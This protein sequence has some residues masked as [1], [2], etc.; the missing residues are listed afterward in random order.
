MPY[1]NTSMSTGSAADWD[2]VPPC[3]AAH[4]YFSSKHVCRSEQMTESVAVWS[5]W[6]LCP[7]THSHHKSSIY[8]WTRLSFSL[9]VVQA[10]VREYKYWQESQSATYNRS[11]TFELIQRNE[12]KSPWPSPLFCNR[13]R[14]VQHM[15]RIVTRSEQ[16]KKVIIAT[17]STAISVHGHM[18]HM[19]CLYIIL[20]AL[21][22][23]NKSS[24]LANHKD[25]LQILGLM[26]RGCLQV[27]C[28][29]WMV[30]GDEWMLSRKLFH[31]QTT[32]SICNLVCLCN[33]ST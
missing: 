24:Q 15:L 2:F 30:S 3:P 19:V 23:H 8:E 7:A 25:V 22:H 32:S 29:W 18:I 26:K 27:S 1:I 31:P 33:R 20:K 11:L 28:H 16:T 5:S 14:S 10:V 17:L 21:S 9:E 6:L 12:I 4:S 13:T